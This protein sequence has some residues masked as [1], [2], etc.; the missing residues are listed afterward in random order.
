[1]SLENNFEYYLGKLKSEEASERIEAVLAFDEI[2]I[3]GTIAKE[4]CSLITDP[5]KGVRSFLAEQLKASDSPAV[6]AELVKYVS[7]PDLAVKNL[8]GEILLELGSASIDPML[9]FLPKGDNDDK[10]FIVDILGLIGDI[11]PQDKIIE[12]LNTS[13][14]DNVI[15]ACIEALGNIRSENAVSYLISFYS[16]NETFDPAIIEAL[17]KI[18]SLDSLNYIMSKY[19]EE[20]SDLIKFSII[21]SLGI[22]GD[23]KTFFFLLAELNETNGPLVGP[24]IKSLY[25]LKIKFGFDIPFDERT[26]NLVLR[27]VVESNSEYRKIAV[28]L[29]SVFNEKETLSVFLKIIG[30]EP[31]TDEIIFNMLLENP[32]VF[33]G[34]ISEI[35]EEEPDNLTSLLTAFKEITLQLL[36]DKK[37]ELYNFITPIQLRDIS[38]TLSG[39]LKDYSEEIR[40]LALEVLFILDKETAILFFDDLADDQNIWNKLKLLEMLEDITHPKAEEILNKLLNDPDEMIRER[41]EYSLSLRKP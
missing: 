18:G 10:K 25:N 30:D 27:T 34:L 12:L 8:A 3:T 28:H 33:F 21:E 7:Y 6:P 24:I 9:D 5:D 38:D 13:E 4:L 19:E 39:Y 32:V 11:S 40:I 15:L 29:L 26:K 20:E 2:L 41:A 1:M 17:G 16:V 37:E 35:L 14:N 22:V 23:E 31:E 36:A